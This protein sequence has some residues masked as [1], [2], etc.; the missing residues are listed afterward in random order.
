M[1]KYSK[2]IGNYLGWKIANF[3]G[4]LMKNLGRLKK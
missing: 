2:K 3:Y 4:S 1:E